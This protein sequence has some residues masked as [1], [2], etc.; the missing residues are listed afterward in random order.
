MVRCH[1][2]PY[3]LKRGGFLLAQALDLV[4]RRL[5]HGLEER[6]LTEIYAFSLLLNGILP[7]A[8]FLMP[9]PE[10]RG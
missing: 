3:G 8:G 6:N 9:I 7:P 4:S 2:L 10:V 5:A 1:C